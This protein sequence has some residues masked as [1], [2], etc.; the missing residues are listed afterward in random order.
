MLIY[1]SDPR[2][3]RPRAIVPSLESA[4]VTLVQTG[5][6]HGFHV[7]ART[8]ARPKAATRH[9]YQEK[10]GPGCPRNQIPAP[11]DSRP[12]AR[13]RPT[14]RRVRRRALDRQ[15]LMWAPGA[16]GLSLHHAYVF[17]YLDDGALGLTPF[18]AAL[19]DPLPVS[20]LR[21]PL[22]PQRCSRRGRGRGLHALDLWFGGWAGGWGQRDGFIWGG[23]G[24]ARQASC[25][26]R[27]A[28]AAAA[29]SAR[30]SGGRPPSNPDPQCPPAAAPIP[31]AVDNI[32]ARAEGRGGAWGP[33]PGACAG[34][35]AG[36]NQT[37]GCC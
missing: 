36:L 19:E 7:G 17:A 22:K 2:I 25:S 32:K 34:A 29:R 8:S 18:L 33:R 11:P 13:A 27:L 12:A 3:W 30:D 35:G 9:A 1:G 37:R 10:I 26:N 23:G 14:D 28:L 31:T 20:Q 21:A 24:R 5:R 15:A 16:P 4:A 6:A